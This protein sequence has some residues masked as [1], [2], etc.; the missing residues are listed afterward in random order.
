LIRP[1]VSIITPCYR[2]EKTIGRL[3]EAVRAQTYPVE[4]MEVVVADGISDDGTLREIELFRRSRPELCVRVLENPDRIIPSALNRAIAASHGEI[5][6][7][8]DGHSLPSSEYVATCVELLQRG[9]GDMVGGVWRIQPG[10]GSWQASAIAAAAS[11]PFGVGDAY[12]RWA[13]SAREVDTLAFWAFRKAWIDRVGL[14]DE[15]LHSNEDY[16][17]N[18]R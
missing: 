14:F 2:E 5:L 11:H 10:D 4:M 7:R 8:L 12:Y 16:D 1:L 13:S 3:L 18:S 9:K 17:F 6:L 15:T